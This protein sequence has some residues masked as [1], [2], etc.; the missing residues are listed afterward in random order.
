M[1]VFYF[2]HN[3][4]EC[5][6]QVLLGIAEEYGLLLPAEGEEGLADV[7]LDIGGEGTGAIVIFVVALAGVLGDEVLLDGTLHAA[8]HVVVHLA[9]AVGHDDGLVTGIA[10]TALLLHQRVAEVDAGGD[11][12]VFWQVVSEY[13]AQAVLAEGAA[14]GVAYDIAFGFLGEK[15]L[16]G[17]GSLVCCF[18]HDSD[19]SAKIII[20]CESTKHYSKNF[21]QI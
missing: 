8:R 7:S 1:I 2:G 21:L 15:S 14:G 19:F 5:L 3:S 18:H 10:W 16:G 6:P 11:E 12:L 4:P 20:L 17:K 13:A 9:E